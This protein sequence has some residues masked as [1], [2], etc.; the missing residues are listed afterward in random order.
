MSTENKG[1]NA[2]YYSDGTYEATYEDATEG[3]AP[4]KGTW[5][6]SDGFFVVDKSVP[7]DYVG[8][9]WFSA[10]RKDAPSEWVGET[11]APDKVVNPDGSWS[12]L[13]PAQFRGYHYTGAPGGTLKTAEFAVDPNSLK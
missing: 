7:R 3:T 12:Q 1:F 6:T 8:Q 5:E 11:R 4:I 2:R 13:G 9:V 10:P